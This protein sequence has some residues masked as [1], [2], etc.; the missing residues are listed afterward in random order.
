MHHSKSL[1]DVPFIQKML[2]IQIE[3]EDDADEFKKKIDLVS[4]IVLFDASLGD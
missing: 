1:V 2:E 3:E 4:D